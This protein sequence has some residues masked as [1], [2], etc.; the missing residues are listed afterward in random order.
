MKR[1]KSAVLSLSGPRWDTAA[2]IL[3]SIF[4]FF[5]MNLWTEPAAVGFAF[6][7]LALVLG[8]TPWRLA[9]ERFGVAVLG[10]LG[11]MLMNGL[12]AVYSPYGGSAARDFRS[13]LPAFAVAAVILLRFEKRHVRKLLWAFAVLSAVV[14]LLCTSCSCEG[15]LFDGFRGVMRLFGAE[16]MYL[17][18]E[19]TVGRVNGIYNDANVSGSIFAVGTLLSLYLVQS[20]KKWWERLLACVL[21]STSAVGILLSVSRGT[22]LCF[23]ISLLVWIMIAGNENRLRLFLLMVVSAGSSMAAYMLAS[24]AIAP[25]AVLPN[26]ISVGTGAGIFLLDWAV[27]E[28]LARKLAGHGKAVVAVMGVMVILVGVA[29]AA[30]FRM[31]EPFVFDGNNRLYRGVAMEPGEYT[32]SVDWEG[33]EDLSVQIYSHTEADALMSKTTGLYNGPVREALFTVPEETVRVFFRFSGSA[34]SVI[35]SVTLSNGVQLPLTYKVLPES[36]VTRLQEN[37]FFDNSFLLRAQF[38]KDAWELIKQKPVLGYGIGATD[39]LYPTIQPFYYTSRYVHNHLLQA[40]TDMGLFGLIPFLAFLGGVFWLLLRRLWKGDALAAV[41][42]ACW[43]MMNSHS[44]MEINFS[45][46]AYQCFAFPFLLLPVIL[47][48]E[49]L[50]E[51]AARLGGI[52]VCMGLW[53]Y[54]AVFGGLL[55]VRQTVRRESDMLR[56]GSME[57]LMTALESYARRDVFDPAP[58][59]L[60]YV[61]AAVQDQSGE[62]HLKMLEYVEKIRKSENYPA[63]SGLPEHYYLAMGDFEG[64]FACSRACL[65]QRMSYASVWNGQMDFYRTKVL[66]AAGEEHMGEFVA[67]VLAFRSYLD[68]VNS[69]GRFEEILLSETNRTFVETV[70]SARDAGTSDAELYRQL[71]EETP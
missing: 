56:A 9:R 49:P 3:F 51:K 61:A 17:D 38:D 22:I 5:S 32:L 50:T 63:C 41:L 16:S 69:R 57:E 6:I 20:G 19:N 11:F 39:N 27:V 26:L 68:E 4:L 15:A 44:L 70:V 29:A 42:M 47:Y 54:L 34:G 24:T 28:R 25:G 52:G 8:R 21:V 67:G 31:T 62:Y 7:A 13:I 55:G 2:V 71:T 1:K 14:S 45:V 30:A 43:V 66:P 59:Q 60:E 40:M 12:S 10:F 33:G 37:I 46:Q 23:G 35:H 36:L 18:L 65:A 48:A 64:L 58:Y 53:L